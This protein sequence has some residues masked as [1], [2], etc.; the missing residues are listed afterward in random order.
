MVGTFIRV[1]T[2]PQYKSLSLLGLC[3]PLL[4]LF[5][6]FGYTVCR[7]P[8]PRS[9]VE[10]VPL[11]VETQSPNHWTTREVPPPAVL[12]QVL[13]LL[14]TQDALDFLLADSKCKHVAQ[15]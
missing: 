4:F 15:T 2:W 11:A 14:H 3:L 8:V 5:L 9:G 7:S 1:E 6:C 13:I 12:R 10:P